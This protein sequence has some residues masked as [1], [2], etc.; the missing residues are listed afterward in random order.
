MR[1]QGVHTI[2]PAEETHRTAYRLGVVGIGA[3][4]IT[5]DRSGSGVVVTTTSSTAPSA[6]ERS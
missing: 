1:D 3:V 2:A 5:H 6:R 4:R